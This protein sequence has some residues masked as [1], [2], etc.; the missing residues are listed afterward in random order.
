MSATGANPRALPGFDAVTVWLIVIAAMVFFMAVL[1]GVTRLTQSGLSIVAWQPIMGTLPPMTDA[2]WT[3]AFNAYKR[4]PEY[5]RLNYGMTLD[6]FK[7]IFWMEYFHR[8]WGRVIG[9]AFAL[10]LLWFALRRRVRGRLLW[11]LAG[12]LVLGGLQGAMGWIMVRSGLVDTPSVSPYRLAAHLSLAFVIYMGLLWLIFTRTLTPAPAPRL[13]VPAR[14][15]LVLVMVTI[16]SG[17]FVAGLDAGMTYNTFPLMDGQWVPDGLFAA[18]PAWRAAFEDVTTVQF[19]HRV[20]AIVT[21]CAILVLA[22][23]GTD[24]PL[25]RR[26]RASALA[27]GLMALVQVVLGIATLVL[28]VPVGLGALHQAGAMVLLGL[29]TWAVYETHRRT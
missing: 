4:Y 20:L 24:E 12:L 22:L 7:A 27:A 21:F 11:A 3:E 25:P 18:E 29:A 10:P 26:A 16:V 19:D 14:V 5:Q 8:L 23:K 1:G 2:A 15:A 28:V 6:E 13:R 17:A 9:L